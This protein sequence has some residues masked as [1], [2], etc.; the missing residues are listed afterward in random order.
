MVRMFVRTVALLVWISILLTS[1]S[2]AAQPRSFA[3][4]CELDLIL[5]VSDTSDERYLGL[6]NREDL[7]ED[8][9]MLFVFEEPGVYGFVMRNMNFPLDI[10]WLNS[11]Y[12]VI[13]IVEDAQPE[14]PRP[15]KLYQPETPAQYVLEINA[16]LVADYDIQLGDQL[17]L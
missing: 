14:G 16:G 12:E 11:N 17:K 6:S 15:T 5:E 2:F 7:A 9:G 1:L 13:H 3:E 10:L 8:E 4:I